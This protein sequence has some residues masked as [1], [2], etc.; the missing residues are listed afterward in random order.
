MV[1]SAPFLISIAHH[2]GIVPLSCQHQQCETVAVQPAKAGLITQLM[3]AL[4]RES[5][6]AESVEEPLIWLNYDFCIV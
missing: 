1:T 5:E 2:H 6:K 4:K 3:Q